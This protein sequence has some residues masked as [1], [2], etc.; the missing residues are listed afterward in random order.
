MMC[1]IPQHIHANAAAY[2][3]SLGAF[4]VALSLSLRLALSSLVE[5]P[6]HKGLSSV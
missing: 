6:A 3:C 5:G 1:Y 2:V 4:L